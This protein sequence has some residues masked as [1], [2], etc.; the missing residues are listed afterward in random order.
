M[1]DY[2]ISANTGSIISFKAC[3]GP[4]QQF[5]AWRRNLPYDMAEGA[6]YECA[7][8]EVA[9]RL[10]C[11]IDYA[12][13]PIRMHN[14]WYRQ[15]LQSS[16]IDDWLRFCGPG[17]EVCPFWMPEMIASYM[18]DYELGSDIDT[19]LSEKGYK[20]PSAAN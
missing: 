17:A 8:F 12:L 1:A 4:G 11:F 3:S 18:V 10:E 13:S 16:M 9:R 14:N 19:I 5:G 15:V 20:I 7:N 6:V 2:V